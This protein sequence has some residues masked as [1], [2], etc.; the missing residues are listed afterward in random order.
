MRIPYKI[1]QKEYKKSFIPHLSGLRFHLDTFF[2]NVLFRLTPLPKFGLN[3]APRRETVTLSLTTYPKRINQAYVAIKSLML[4]SEKADKIVLWLSKEQFESYPLPKKFNRLIKRG[5][6]VRYVDDLM[7]HKKYYYALQEQKMN[8]LVITYD[9]DIIYEKNSVKKLLLTHNIF[10]D[11]IVCNRGHKIE[12]DENGI[13]P[14]KEWKWRF[15]DGVDKPVMNIVPSTGNGCLYPYGVVSKSTFDIELCKKT[16]WTAD[17]IWMR[18]N[19]INNG[20]FVVRTQKDV[21]TL[22]NVY[23]SQKTALKQVNDGQ[24]EN[25]KTVDRLKKVFPEVEKQIKQ[26]YRKQ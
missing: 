10:P 19:S 25:Q 4:Q 24:N 9:D 5:L 15:N 20:V 6:K 11:C 13:K 2:E 14:Y 1:R 22:I 23:S 21:A 26:T 3:T 16:A 17:D 7:S 12:F 8:E 18:F